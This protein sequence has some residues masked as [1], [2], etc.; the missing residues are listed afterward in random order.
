MLVLVSRCV[1]CL[2]VSWLVCWL[3]GLCD[4]CLFVGLLV[5]WLVGGLDCWLAGCVYVMFVCWSGVVGWSVGWFVGWR[6]CR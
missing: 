5:C 6:V 2:L 1:V 3:V 4:A